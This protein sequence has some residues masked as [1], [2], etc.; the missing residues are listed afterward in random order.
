MKY[1]V[2][3]VVVAVSIS[4]YFL[5]CE[6]EYD[7][8]PTQ[9][10]SEFETQSLSKKPVRSE[11]ITFSG[12]LIGAQEVIGCC[13]NAGPFPDYT[14]SLSGDLPAGTYDGQIF[15]N[16]LGVGQNQSYIVQFW[17]NTLFIEVR[18]GLIEQ[19]KKNKITTVT[20]TAEPCEIWINDV[21]TG[22]VP[23]DFVLTR[24]AL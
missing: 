20:F 19:N 14:M 5:G 21:L 12:D 9:N 24:A 22:T 8:L 11:L 16:Y 2:F 6:N 1:L 18:G 4:F 10:P 7:G 17:T 13:P 23:V 3:I 15:M